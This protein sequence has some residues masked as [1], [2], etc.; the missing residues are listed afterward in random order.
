[1]ML[2]MPLFRCRYVGAM[3]RCFAL[4]LFMTLV[5]ER[6]FL[7][8]YACRCRAMRADIHSPIT[9]SSYA[10]AAYDDAAARLAML[11]FHATALF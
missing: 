4:R 3:P 1:L 10:C 9:G 2:L 7:R 6:A 8:R 11:R 5:Y